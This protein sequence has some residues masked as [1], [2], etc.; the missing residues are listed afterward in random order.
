MAKSKVTRF[1]MLVELAQNELDK[2]QE[3]FI[4]I[5]Q[6]LDSSQEQFNSLTEYQANHLSKFYNEKQVNVA[7]LQTTQAFVDKVNKAILSQKNQ[8]ENLTHSLEKAQEVWI[9]K[10]ARH[11][12]LK[13]V[14]LKL[15]RDESVKLDK[16]EQKMLDELATQRF[17]QSHS[18][19]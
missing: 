8:I 13:T 4:T 6:Q 11:Q 17:V 2:A 5:R 12:A 14:H 9:E 10:R 16:Q 7:Q 19:E 15:K 1:E 3:T 18:S